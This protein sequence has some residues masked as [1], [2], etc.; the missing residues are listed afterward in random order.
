MNRTIIGVEVNVLYYGDK[1]MDFH[2]GCPEDALPLIELSLKEG[3]TITIK[4]EYRY[5]EEEAV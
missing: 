1:N 4:N 2:F 3:Y 5:D